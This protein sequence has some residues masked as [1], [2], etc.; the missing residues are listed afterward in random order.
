LRSAVGQAWRRGEPSDAVVGRAYER[1]LQKR[2]QR[3]RGAL[4]LRPA[5]WLALGTLLGV[6]SLYA[7]TAGPWPF[8]GRAATPPADMASLATSGRAAVAVRPSARASATPAA[9]TEPR[10]PAQA[11]PT[12]SASASPGTLPRAPQGKTA[13]DD[14]QRAA[15]GLREQDFAS[16]DDAFRRLAARG[17]AP[18][19]E[20]ALLAR[21][22]LLLSQGRYAT[23]HEL[24][25]RLAASAESSSIRRSAAELAQRAS[26][27][28]QSQ[29]SFDPAP[30]TNSP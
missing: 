6:G 1:F 27:F 24:A 2:E 16:A 19:R 29:R 5:A 23:A 11:A 9:S 14:W 8:L 15:R 12:S 7:A 17:D 25:E 20:A 13:R 30:S 21:A 22:Q 26:Q 3:R 4:L 28:T 10:A 18:E